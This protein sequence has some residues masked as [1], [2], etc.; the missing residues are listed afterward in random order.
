MMPY[1]MLLLIVFLIL[2]LSGCLFFSDF[3]FSGS[4]LCSSGGSS[5]LCIG[6]SFDSSLS[7]S[8]S[9]QLSSVLSN[10]LYRNLHGH[11]LVEVYESY[12]V[13]NLLGILH[14]DDLTINI[15]TQL[16]ELVGHMSS[17]YRTVELTSSTHLGSDLEGY[18]IEL[19]S[20]LLGSSLQGSELVSLLLQVL[21]EDLLS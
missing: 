11:L 21:S 1:S 8:S 9:L 19:S 10:N 20:L 15:L 18:T 13:A 3:L 16:C 7:L 5:S 6:S 12:I 17:T 2:C 14:G 4:L